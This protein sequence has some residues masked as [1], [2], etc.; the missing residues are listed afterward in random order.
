MSAVS[1]YDAH[2]HL[3]D[4]RIRGDCAGVV[5]RAKEAGVDGMM[6]CGAEE[7][8]WNEVKLIGATYGGVGVS[9]GLHP[10]YAARRGGS[11]LDR[12]RE[13]LDQNERAGVGEIGLDHA[14]DRGTFDAQEEV[15]TAQLA[16][17]RKRGRAVSVHCRRAWERLLTIVSREKL[18]VPGVVHSYSGSV[19]LIGSLCGL[20]FFFSF[21]GAV[22]FERNKRGRAALAA[23]PADR[24]LLET[25]SPDLT[26]D[27]VNSRDNEPSNL[28]R[29]A[30]IASAL[31]GLP[32]EEIARTTSANAVRV[33]GV[34]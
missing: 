19:E 5:A 15:F 22:T 31:R 23:V 14:V 26:P 25:D 3:Q 24:L 11:W 21:S 16:E 8:D 10:W 2:C 13:L 20:G 27:G 4:S 9:F 18:S 34:A 32:F 7:D 33:F 28:P 6:C 12:L 17:A 29:V 1:L 30:R